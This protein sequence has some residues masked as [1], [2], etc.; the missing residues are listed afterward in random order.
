MT[1]ALSCDAPAYIPKPIRPAPIAARVYDLKRLGIA[2]AELIPLLPNSKKPDP[3]CTKWGDA[4]LFDGKPIVWGTLYFDLVLW[5]LGVRLGV[6]SGL[7]VLDIDR[8]EL[9]QTAL[10]ETPQ[11]FTVRT[12][13][14]IHRYYRLPRERRLP[15]TAF[16]GGEVLGTGRY[17]VAPGSV[18]ID[19]KRSELGPH[20]YEIAT[21][22]TPRT[23]GEHLIAEAPQWLLE[24]PANLP[25]WIPPKAPAPAPVTYDTLTSEPRRE[26]LTAPHSNVSGEL[27]HNT[28]TD[29][30]HVAS[31]GR[32]DLDATLKRTRYAC[33]FHQDRS[34][35]LSITATEKVWKCH[36]TRCDLG[37]GV[38]D[39]WRI[40]HPNEPFPLSTTHSAEMLAALASW[41][42]VLARPNTT[43]TDTS[44]RKIYAVL[45]DRATRAHSTEVHLGVRLIAELANVSTLTAHRSLDRLEARGLIRLTQQASRGKAATYELRRDIGNT[46][47]MV[48][49]K[50]SSCITFVPTDLHRDAWHHT[51]L[52]NAW[53]TAEHLR[54]LTH[55]T[56]AGL[57]ELTGHH[58]KTVRRHLAKLRSA[59]LV[60]QGGESEWAW[61]PATPERER[62]LLDAYAELTQLAGRTAR[63]KVAHE[64]ERVAYKQRRL[65]F[66]KRH[67]LERL[68]PPEPYDEPDFDQL[69]VA[70]IDLLI[71][72]ASASLDASTH[73][74]ARGAR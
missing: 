17:V 69:T 71:L 44:D 31:Q 47:E 34:P 41:H 65:E 72:N 14:G 39:L 40:V 48:S 21:L 59:G 61:I 29:L 1:L 64:L 4:V 11:T 3:T 37:G 45:V 51:G 28:F 9:V 58:P 56:V 62:S 54:A 74:L 52:G 27:W 36:S 32:I 8:P 6:T 68:V 35:S 2:D 10:D 73:L 50:A 63:K 67:E 7:I 38:T 57:A 25:A 19:E 42:A 16:T 66:A 20:R 18:V 26:R 22:W 15:S 12:R 70:K 33:P 55:S 43:R 13:R 30:W 24:G 46:S 23:G 49:K 60:A 5:N 53:S